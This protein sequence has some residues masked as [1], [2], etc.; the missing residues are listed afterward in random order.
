MFFGITYGPRMKRLLLIKN[1][2]THSFHARIREQKSMLFLKV[3]TLKILLMN[4]FYCICS[5]ETQK[6]K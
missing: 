6:Y 2:I 4:I 1:R 5:Q 3:F